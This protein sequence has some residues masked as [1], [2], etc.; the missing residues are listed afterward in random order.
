MTSNRLI[1]AVGLLSVAGLVGVAAV[2]QSGAPQKPAAK[3]KAKPGRKA[4]PRI[5]KEHWLEHNQV[6]KLV[7]A[8]D[9]VV[10]YFD[11]DVPR[12]E[13]TAWTAR[14]MGRAWRYTKATYG[15]FG[16]PDDRLYAIFH[17]GRYSG[18]HPSTYFDASHDHRNVTDCGP[19]PW[20]VWSPAIPSHE[21]GHIVEGAS[22]GVHESP[23][24]GLWKDSK[25]IELYQYD[26]YV[27]LGL[28][29]QARRA[30]DQFTAQTDDFPRPGTHWFRDFFYPAWRDHGRSRL[31]PAFFRL[32]AQH[33][34]KG[35]EDNGKAIKYTRDMNWGEFIHFMSGAAHKDLRPLARK[36][37]G[38]PPERERHF[39]RAR[40]EFPE[41]VYAA[42]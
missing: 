21:I 24:F 8:D 42:Q 25:W 1:M 20:G 30:F 27:G 2:A 26:L 31:M 18:G 32:L 14:F 7:H 10:I 29:D 11:D 6:L 12:G 3:A 22:H 5:W 35:P 40:E 19:G 4:P 39:Q 34:P 37:F 28:E 13:A 33:Y 41:I 15:H 38:W 36:A 9:D 16:G 17:Q 23:A